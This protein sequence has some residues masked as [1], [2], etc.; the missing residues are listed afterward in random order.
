[1]SGKAALNALQFKA[2]AGD[3]LSEIETNV[4]KHAQKY[5]PN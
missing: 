1:M 3:S 2:M 5:L 4:L